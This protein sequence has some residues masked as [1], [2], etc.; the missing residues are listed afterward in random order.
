[1]DVVMSVKKITDDITLPVENVKEVF[2][3]T[4]GNFTKIALRMGLPFRLYSIVSSI[5][6]R[7]YIDFLNKSG[8]DMNGIVISSDDFG[9]VCYAV[10]DGKEQRYFM[11]EGPM[12]RL[13]YKVLDE[14]YSYLHLGTG[15]PELN[16]QLMEQCSYEKLSFDP[17]QEIFYK[18]SPEQIRD[19]INR[20]DF[21]MGNEK[22]IRFMM[23]K[24]GMDFKEI[25]EKGKIIIMTR[26]AEGC[27]VIKDH[28][29]SIPAY[30][31]VKEGDTLGAG[32]SFRAG[33]YYGLYNNLTLE[34]SAACGNI[35]SYF[36]VRNGLN[37]FDVDGRKII[38][39]GKEL[40]KKVIYHNGNLRI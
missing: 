16:Y 28:S 5:S 23:D 34:E 18:Y 21:I 33:F 12:K 39:M 36:V 27:T 20:S 1:M 35:V 17:S 25:M 30:D 37:N 11:A 13:T 40:S 9:P 15:N 14:K 32:D 31:E 19:F 6:H 22:E 38:E 26:G 24:T 3:G 29:F 10:N 7:S 4:A 2:G 8:F